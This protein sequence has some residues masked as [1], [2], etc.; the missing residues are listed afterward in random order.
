V[1]R[2]ALPVLIVLDLAVLLLGGLF[3]ATDDWC[4]GEQGQQSGFTCYIPD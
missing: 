4:D 3:V 1:R 2:V